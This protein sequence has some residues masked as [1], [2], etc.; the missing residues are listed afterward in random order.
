MS[1]ERSEYD[2]KYPA[3]SQEV[4]E[5]LAGYDSEVLLTVFLRRCPTYL[6]FAHLPNEE[7]CVVVV[8]GNEVSLMY[9]ISQLADK[10]SYLLSDAREEEGSK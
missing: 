6:V 2:S 7:K 9:G 3:I 4:L 1:E 10:A 8:Q 5:D